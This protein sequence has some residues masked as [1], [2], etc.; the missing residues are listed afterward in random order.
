MNRNFG[1]FELMEQNQ[2]R[3][4]SPPG[5]TIIFLGP[6]GPCHHDIRS[7]SMF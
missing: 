3:H 4:L 7:M 5:S 1:G 2:D 6:G